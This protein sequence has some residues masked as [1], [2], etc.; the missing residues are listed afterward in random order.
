MATEKFGIENLRTVFNFGVSFGKLVATDLEDH[1]ISFAEGLGLVAKL[2]EVQD[3]V[4]NKDA[5]IA[6]AK[7]LSFDEIKELL[8][9]VQGVF[10]NQDV[11]DTIEDAITIAVV[12][13]RVIER[14]GKQK[15][16]DTS[17]ASDGTKKD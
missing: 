16:A 6:E 12:A 11:V 1:K 15:A 14:F 3:I 13:K 5:I 17:V 10:T 4:A 2:S 7:D 8:K 9:D